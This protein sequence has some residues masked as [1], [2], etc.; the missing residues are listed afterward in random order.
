MFPVV[1]QAGPIVG[2]PLAV[3]TFCKMVVV[4]ADKLSATSAHHLH[5]TRRLAPDYKTSMRLKNLY[6]ITRCA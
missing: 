4:L 5:P 6:E 3:L 2:T 1:P